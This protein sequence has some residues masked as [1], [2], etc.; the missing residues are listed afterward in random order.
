MCAL[1]GK[2]ISAVNRGYGM[3]RF[4][5][6][7]LPQIGLPN[8]YYKP[9]PWGIPGVP[10]DDD[11]TQQLG[12]KG[13]LDTWLRRKQRTRGGAKFAK[14]SPEAK[15]YMAKLRAMRTSKKR[16]GKALLRRRVRGGNFFTDLLSDISD[17]GL[18]MLKGLAAEGHTSIMELISNPAKLIAL[19]TS[20]G[21][22]VL[23]FVKRILGISKKEEEE[24]ERKKEEEKAKKDKK[25]LIYLQYLKKVDPNAYKKALA[26]YERQKQMEL[27]N[28]S[29]LDEFDD[30]PLDLSS[31][32]DDDETPPPLPPRTRPRPLARKNN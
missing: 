21:P 13:D 26:A 15:A 17:S 32:I 23:S 12:F 28:E 30:E 1:W 14:G 7:T 22:A 6:I 5:G 19:A 4:A 29:G 27:L 9:R 3:N 25:K 8:P 24:A 20:A 31:A 16:G 11:I 18:A 2:T 10:L